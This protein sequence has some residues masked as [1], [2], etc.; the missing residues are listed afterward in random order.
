MNS[1]PSKNSF[2]NTI[3]GV[4]VYNLA[5]C[6]LMIATTISNHINQTVVRDVIHIP[7]NLIGMSFYNYFILCFWVYNSHCTTISIGN[8]LV[9][10]RFYV[11]HPQFLTVPFVAGWGCIV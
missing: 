9:Y 6:Y 7:G 4:N 10:I 2:Y 3:F 5:R 11:V 1:W 8:K